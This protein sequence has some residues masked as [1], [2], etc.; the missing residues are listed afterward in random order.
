MKTKYTFGKRLRESRE[1]LGY[2]QAE[3][4]QFVHVSATTLFK[5]ETGQTFPDIP[6]LF[7]IAEMIGCQATWLLGE[8]IIEPAKSNEAP[9]GK[10]DQ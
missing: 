10:G 5:Y 1:Y 2:T 8:K 4:A 9:W 3:M 7:Q 6:M